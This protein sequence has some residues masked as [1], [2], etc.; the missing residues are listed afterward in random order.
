MCHLFFPPIFI[1]FDK[2]SLVFP[3][4]DFFLFSSPYILITAPF[5]PIACKAYSKLDAVRY[6]GIFFSPI[7]SVLDQLFHKFRALYQDIGE[8]HLAQKR[9]ATDLG[10]PKLEWVG[11]DAALCSVKCRGL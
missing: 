9:P 10:P 11:R 1:F 8:F 4:Q 2:F 3:L 7:A 6:F 5:L